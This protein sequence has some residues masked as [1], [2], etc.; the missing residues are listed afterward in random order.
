MGRLLE[1]VRAEIRAAHQQ[2]P[3][4]LPAS[5]QP[6]SSGQVRFHI[7]MYLCT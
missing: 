6:S 2:M 1:V 3:P 5:S 4:S 7:W